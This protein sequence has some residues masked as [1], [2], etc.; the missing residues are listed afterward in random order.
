[1]LSQGRAMSSDVGSIPADG[2]D[3]LHFLRAFRQV[4]ES[5]VSVVSMFRVRR[6]SGV[7]QSSVAS[8]S[9]LTSI[10]SSPSLFWPTPL[11]SPQRRLT[12]ESTVAVSTNRAV[13]VLRSRALSQMFSWPQM[14]AHSRANLSPLWWQGMI[15]KLAARIKQAP[16]L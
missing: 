4:T 11:T 13:R 9:A 8:N 5:G 6:C 16:D 10:S 15:N 3:Y 14:M 12:G 7:R 1:M 2:G